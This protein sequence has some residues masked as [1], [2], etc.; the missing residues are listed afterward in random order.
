M[1]SLGT[2][3]ILLTSEIIYLLIKMC[4]NGISRTFANNSGN[5][6]LMHVSC[7]PNVKSG[8]KGN[9]MVIPS[10]WI[11]IIYGQHW[12]WVNKYRSQILGIEKRS[13]KHKQIVFSGANCVGLPYLCFN[14][15]FTFKMM[16]YWP[17]LML[18][19]LHQK[20][21]VLYNG[22]Q[23]SKQQLVTVQV[24][25]FQVVRVIYLISQKGNLV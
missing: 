15:I 19:D 10:L 9:S 13:Y 8:L 12:K 25:Y 7:F 24:Y 16:H 22:I 14:R 1:F 4:L 6:W 20:T 23:F 5:Q 18:I 17:T 2:L 11:C 3:F 21:L